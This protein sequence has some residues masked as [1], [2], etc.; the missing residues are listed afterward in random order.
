MF[1]GNA[2]HYVS[3]RQIEA[4]IA[5]LKDTTDTNEKIIIEE[6]PQD[7]VNVR[8]I[9]ET[10]TINEN[11][12]DNTS[13]I[14]KLK[15][16]VPDVI[17]ESLEGKSEEETIDILFDYLT[18]RKSELPTEPIT[19]EFLKNRSQKVEKFIEE[20]SHTPHPEIGKMLEPGIWTVLP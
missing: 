14:D 17:T 20:H 7:V 6:T 19:A 13:V 8:P 1:H 18:K 2:I 10:I 12:I 11:E 3:K 9:E 15:S 5:I 16:K 4:E